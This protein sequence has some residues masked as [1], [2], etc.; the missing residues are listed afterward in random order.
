VVATIALASCFIMLDAKTV[1]VQAIV[2]KYLCRIKFSEQ[3]TVARCKHKLDK[4]DD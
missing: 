4:I 1:Q 2:S 3:M